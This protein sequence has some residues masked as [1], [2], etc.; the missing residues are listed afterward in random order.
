MARNTASRLLVATCA[1]VLVACKTTDVAPPTVVLTTRS[2]SRTPIYDNLSP[3]D[4]E[5][6]DRVLRSCRDSVGGCS[7]SLL[8][9]D[10]EQPVAMAVAESV[11]GDGRADICSRLGLLHLRGVA[12]GTSREE[13]LRL[14][15][16][17]CQSS[18]PVACLN[19][20][21]ALG[22]EPGSAHAE[23]I[24]RL[25]HFACAQ[26]LTAGCALEEPPPPPVRPPVEVH[27]IPAAPVDSP[28]T[29]TPAATGSVPM[30]TASLQPV[31]KDLPVL[32]AR[33]Q[34][35]L[36]GAVFGTRQ[37]PDQLARVVHASAARVWPTVIALDMEMQ[38][39]TRLRRFLQ[40]PG[41]A[42]ALEELLQGFWR[43]P[44][45]DGRSSKAVLR[46]LLQVRADIAQGLP[47]TVLPIDKP[48]QGNAHTT[49]IADALTDLHQRFPT[50]VVIA[51]LANRQAALVAQTL[52]RR[53]IPLVSV[54]LAHDGGEAWL[55]QKERPD[56]FM[57]LDTE[58]DPIQQLREL[59]CREARLSAMWADGIP[60]SVRTIVSD[61]RGDGRGLLYAGNFARDGFDFVFP[62]GPVTA[63]WPAVPEQR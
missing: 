7:Q 27:R 41:D 42:G 54:H 61:S 53:G 8:R 15:N 29:E 28:G 60:D 56:P 63:S 24:R 22:Q 19:L 21:I 3:P 26:G 45:Q 36:L 6:V 4:R 33:G 55:C 17:A 34:V 43:R 39:T 16:V 50:G 35:L 11:C 38:E 62:L 20:A 18:L 52:R 40:G 46:M 48:L 47:L 5:E 30:R 57:P 59:S 49:A 44:Y 13:G 31:G 51:L 25:T 2:E 10:T 23:D 1:G 37:A 32:L 12:R 58:L 14:V 9:L